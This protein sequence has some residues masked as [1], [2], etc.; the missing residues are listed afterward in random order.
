MDGI[1]GIASIEAITVCIGGAIAI[2][3]HKVPQIQW[4]MPVL[5]AAVVAG[6][7]FWNFPVAKIFM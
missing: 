7:L 6:F 1:D 3:A 5:L 2:S 4:V